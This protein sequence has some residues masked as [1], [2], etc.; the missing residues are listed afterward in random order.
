LTGGGGGGVM[1][2]EDNFDDDEM[3]DFDAEAFLGVKK[4]NLEEADI[5]SGANASLMEKYIQVM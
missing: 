2:E 5:F 4:E 3:E 1:P